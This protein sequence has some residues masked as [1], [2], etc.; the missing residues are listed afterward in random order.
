MTTAILGG[1]VY[2]PTLKGTRLELKI[3]AETQNGKVFK[4]AGQGMP[5]LKSSL[6]GDLMAKV[7]IQIPTNLSSKERKLFEELKEIRPEEVK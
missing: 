1:K 3:P 7:D 2:V 6:F 5:K 4:L